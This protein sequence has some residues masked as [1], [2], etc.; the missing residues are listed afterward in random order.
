MPGARS[1]LLRAG[2]IDGAAAVPGDA[3][4]PSATTTAIT[5]TE[6]TRFTDDCVPD[7]SD[8][9]GRRLAVDGDRDRS[10]A[11]LPRLGHR[12]EPNVNE[13]A[14]DRV[15]DVR[16]EAGAIAGH[17]ELR[18]ERDQRRVD[19]HNASPHRNPESGRPR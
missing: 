7:P 18:P 15:S 9:G 8:G 12:G 6:R 2:S 10:P 4:L 1:A 11:P 19:C 17:V 14:L 13:L 16:G 5:A 3:E